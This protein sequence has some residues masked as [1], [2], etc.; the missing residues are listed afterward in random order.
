MCRGVGDAVHDGQRRTEIGAPALVKHVVEHLLT[1]VNHTDA[2]AAGF[3]IAQEII[4]G[5][6]IVLAKG[7]RVERIDLTEGF[8]TTSLIEK[9]RR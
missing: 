9:I 5:Y 3:I 7:G 4:A 6:D 2:P 1:F 8:S